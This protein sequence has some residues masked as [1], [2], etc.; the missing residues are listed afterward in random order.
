MTDYCI[1]YKTYKSK[2]QHFSV[3]VF[4]FLLIVSIS[5]NSF[6]VLVI[7]EILIIYIAYKY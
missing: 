2:S 5:F 7:P 4:R 6:S 1:L 3:L